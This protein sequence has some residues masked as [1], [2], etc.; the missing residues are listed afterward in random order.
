MLAAL[1]AFVAAGAT[2]LHA[3][4]APLHAGPPPAG[5]TDPLPSA[6]PPSTLA[7]SVLQTG[8]SGG[9]AEALLVGR[10]R[11]TEHRRPSQSAVL[12]RHPHGVMLYDSG[13]GRQVDA[14]FAVNDRFHRHAFRY[15]RSGFLPALDQLERAGWH[16]E[17]VR[18]IV[19]S[20][21]H[22]DHVSGLPDFPD[23]QVWVTPEEREHAQRG[24]PPAFLKSQ[25]DGVR[26]WR[27]LRFDGPPRLG[28]SAS[29]DVFGDGS[30]VLLPL[31]GHTAG[32]VGLWLRLPS[33]RSY[34][35]TGDVTWTIEGVQQAADRSWLL[36]RLLPLDH[37]ERSNQA[38][39]LH[40][41]HI[42]KHHPDI[43]IVP[44]H[45]ENVLK[46]LPSFPALQG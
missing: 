25:F 17:L 8:V 30:V 22:W 18:F 12:I 37:D 32:Q 16:P 40:L 19:P 1:V 38:A 33:G 45:D 42:M 5:V 21:L 36:R 34:L 26:H 28:F 6:R 7:F 24:Q 14:Q 46:T 29:H 23:A 3:L 41:H 31:A 27:D 13:L 43:T 39:I 44:A 10:G 20:H 11:W 15:E 35:F 4:D 2:A 9:A